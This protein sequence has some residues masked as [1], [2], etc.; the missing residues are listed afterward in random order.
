MLKP[1][2]EAE[3][4]NGLNDKKIQ[5]DKQNADIF[6]ERRHTTHIDYVQDKPNLL[7]HAEKETISRRYN[8]MS[9]KVISTT[10][11]VKKSEN[12]WYDRK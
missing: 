4:F 6:V 12:N 1:V 7:T 2:S 3:E 8:K 11:E 10:N 5:S 9:R